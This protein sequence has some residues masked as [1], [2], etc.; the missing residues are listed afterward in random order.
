[1]AEDLI[2]RLPG[3]LR[4]T[5]EEIA[6]EEFRRSPSDAARS[7]LERSITD[8]AIARG[9]NKTA[10]ISRRTPTNDRDG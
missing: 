7:L 9:I 2:I 5:L 10:L 4:A 1:M 3:R 8:R 6:R